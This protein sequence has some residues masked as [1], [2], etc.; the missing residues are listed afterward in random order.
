MFFQCFQFC[1]TFVANLLPDTFV[2]A[3]SFLSVQFEDALKDIAAIVVFQKGDPNLP[4]VYISAD[5]PF[6]LRGVFGRFID[7]ILCGVVFPVVVLYF[8]K[9][10]G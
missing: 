3:A 4:L 10:K 5:L 9:R 2:Q 7:T 6:V 8:G 1:F